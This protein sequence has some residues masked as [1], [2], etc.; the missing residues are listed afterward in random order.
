MLR[1]Y[2]SVVRALD[3]RLRERHALSFDAYGVL[4][5]LVTQ[6][7]GL[8]I[9][10]LGQRRHLSPSGISRAVDRVE[11][12]GLVERR[13]NPEDQRSLLV[14]LT[15]DGHG[16][17]REAQVTHHAT[18]RERLLGRLSQAQLERFGAL[19]EAAVPG[20]VTSRL[21]PPDDGPHDA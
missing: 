11:R 18:V 2:E 7:D 15:P 13:P 17:L 12:E 1:S 10:E 19:W 21:W 5:T 4:V 8:T 16:R 14:V 20:S 3:A 9:G 6:P